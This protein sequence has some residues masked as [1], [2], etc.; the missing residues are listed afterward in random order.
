MMTHGADP[1]PAFMQDGPE[2]IT[3][4]VAPTGDTLWLVRGYTLGRTVLT[5]KRF[6]RA[7]AVRPHVPKLTEAEPSPDSIM[8]MDGAEHAR[9]RR[10]VAGVFTARRIAGM[11]PH[12]RR[13]ADEHLDRMDS[14]G[15]PADI[16][17]DLASPLSLTVLC[18]LLGIPPEDNKKFKDWVEVLFD[19]SSST[20]QQKAGRRLEL[21]EYMADLVDR[22]RSRQ[23]D[24]L[25]TSLIAV[26]DQ[27]ELSTRELL[28]LG[29]ALLTAGY[30]TTIGQ[31]GL[32]LLSVLSDPD[33]RASL[34]TD[35]GLVPSVVEELLRLTPSTPVSF[36]RVALEPVGL[37]G[38]TISAGEAVIVSL[39]HANRDETIFSCPSR[40]LPGERD[41]THL[42]F[43]HGIHRC[44]G[45][46]L[47][48]LQLQIV[49]TQLLERFPGVQLAAGPDAVAWKDGLATRG[50]SRLL[51]TW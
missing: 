39:L 1:L 13:L 44:L 47:A 17:N 40:L 32:M 51:V 33:T 12:I 31:I 50:L 29:L 16:V 46:P 22:K 6:S 21:F 4:V 26:H 48:R 36:P 49:L 27:G 14:A 43:G 30:E 37:G 35:A 3:P 15:P 5:D 20:P 10:I 38:V 2:E 19:I 45:A 25:L 11:A 9:L 7:A 24:D 18:Q 42:T 8:S 41:S 34:G 28:S 23:D